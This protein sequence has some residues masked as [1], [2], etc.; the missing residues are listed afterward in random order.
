MNF[1]IEGG[2]PLSGTISVNSSKNSAVG[3]LC[4]SLLNKSTTTITNM[5][6]IEEVYRIIEVLESI[7]VKAEWKG[8][9]LTITPPKKLSIHS[10]NEES[11]TKTRSIVMFMGPLVHLFKTFKIPQTGGC[12]LG[13]RTVQPHL[14]ALEKLGISIATKTDA[15][16][17][18]VKKLRPNEI[19]LYE[20]GDTVTENVLMAASKIPGKTHVKLASANYMV[21]DLC[22]FLQLF[23]VQIEGI[24]TTTLTIHGVKEINM[25]VSYTLSE[26]PIEAM[27]FLSIAATT[28]SHI[29]ITKC[30]IEFLELELLKLEK[31]GLKFKLS[32]RYVSANGFTELV[33]IET[34]PSKLTAVHEK[35]YARPFPGL[36]IDNLPFFVPIAARAKGQTLIHDWVYENRALYYLELSKLG[37]NLLL[38]DPHRV[39]ITGPTK[40]KAAEVICPP[41]LRPA[42]IIMIT[43]LAAPG[44]SLLR[45]VY[46]INR[47]YEDIATRLKKIGARIE[48]VK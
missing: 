39:F 12:K 40:F 2:K 9:S 35:I 37:V 20:S 7:G 14:F 11:A 30:P 29:T 48:I 27:L 47:G 32:K 26:D 38:A 3:L 44:T 36:N 42:A 22:H 19:V 41:A 4:A 18:S 15:Y 46:S 23:G 8:P 17:V 25:P 5:P 13:S 33:D 10:L 45:N 21:Q 6:K 24:G 1:Q 43:M 31:M 28:N 16:E 34:F